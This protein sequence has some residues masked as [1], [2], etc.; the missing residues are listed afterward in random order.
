[1]NF[2]EKWRGN[3][4]FRIYP[5]NKNNDNKTEVKNNGQEQSTL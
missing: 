3:T 1:M 4:L 2:Y 5:C